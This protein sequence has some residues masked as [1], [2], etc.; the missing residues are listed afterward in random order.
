MKTLLIDNYDSF[1]YN[2]YHLIAEV[3]RVPPVVVRNDACDWDAL[4][5]AK[6]DNIVISPGP[7]TPKNPDDF[8]LCAQVIREAEIPILG[9]CLGHQGLCLVEGGQI[10]YANTVMH[11]RLSAIHHSREELFKGI[12]SPFNAVRY[13]SLV[14]SKVPDTLEVTAYTADGTVMAVRHTFKPLWGVQ[15]H[16]ESICTEYGTQLLRNYRDLTVSYAKKHR[17]DSL[18]RV[19]RRP[20]TERQPRKTLARD[21]LRKTQ[22]FHRQLPFSVASE[23]AFKQLFMCSEG[24]CFW[25]DSALLAGDARFSYMGDDRGPLAEHLSYRQADQQLQ[26]NDNPVTGHQKLFAHLRQRLADLQHQSPDL[27]FDFN[28]GFVG[29]LGYEMKGDCGYHNQHQSPYPD[30][31]WLLADRMLVFDHI[32]ES[33]YLVCLDFAHESARAEHWLNEMEQRLYAIKEQPPL[34][35]KVDEHVATNLSLYSQRLPEAEYLL[36]ID[37]AKQAIKRGE[38]YEVCLTNTLSKTTSADP[39]TTYLALRCRNPAPYAAFIQ[40]G[41]LAILSSSPER[42]ITI[43]RQ[44][45]IETKPIKGTRR[46]LQNPVADEAAIT[47]LHHS[48]KDRSEN[49]MIVDLLRN[50]LSQV[51]EFGSVE[52]KSLF[53]VESYATVHQLVSTIQARLRRDLDALDCIQACFPGGSMTGAPKKRTLDIL[54]TLEKG[55][56]G[57]YSGNIGFLGLNG[58]VDLNIVIRT[59]VMQG[60]RAEIGVGGAIIDLSS[61]MAEL[62]EMRLKSEALVATLASAELNSNH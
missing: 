5:L 36:A 28:L 12:P 1:T 61:P 50:D 6:Y 26:L 46:R 11:G 37:L 52:V 44:G 16:P 40:F 18:A 38:S 48:E 49:L 39:L 34:R 15:F 7:G 55:P 27:P 43:N 3:N 23:R 19:H 47:D 9:V 56:R 4:A 45:L 41:D 54:D 35:K 53:A 32:E 58:C 29:Y 14:V 30:A 60:Q 25:L 8:G 21:T 59:L 62:E 51:A 10:D 20:T 2:L 57:I 33:M 17:R 13:H 22:L 24:A 42:F 31:Q